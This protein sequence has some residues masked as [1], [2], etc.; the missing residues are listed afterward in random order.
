MKHRM[1]VG[2]SGRRLLAT[3]GAIYF[4]QGIIQSYQ[5]NF[6]KPHMVEAGV[7]ADRLAIV[8]S[9]AIVPFVIKWVFGLISDRYALFGLGHRVPYMLIGL[10][11]TGL[12]FLAAYFVDPAARR[13]KLGTDVESVGGSAHGLQRSSG[14]V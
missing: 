12:A 14:A 8:S 7:D 4:V 3:F 11:S 5:L 13:G 6:F 10:V 9:L 2:I 1:D